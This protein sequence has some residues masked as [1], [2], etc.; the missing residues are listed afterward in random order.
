MSIEFVEN[1]NNLLLIYTQNPRVIFIN[2]K[3]HYFMPKLG[4]I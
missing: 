3:Q 1:N 4:N 2:S